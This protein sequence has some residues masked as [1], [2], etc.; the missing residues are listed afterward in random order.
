[1]V[2]FRGEPP[3][4]GTDRGQDEATTGLAAYFLAARMDP[5]APSTGLLDRILLDAAEAMPAAAARTPQEG[6]RPAR[7]LL[8]RLRGV[9]DSLGGLKGAGALA[10]SAAFGF[11]IGLAGGGDIALATVWTETAAVETAESAEPLADIFT[12]VALEE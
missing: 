12:L 2:D 4:S 10:G 9:F 5:P 11:W 1:M 7:G 8:D 3:R 6:R